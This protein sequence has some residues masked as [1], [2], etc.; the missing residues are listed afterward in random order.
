ML[1]T[2]SQA[3]SEEDEFVDIESEDVDSLL[4]IFDEITAELLKEGEILIC[5][6]VT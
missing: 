6:K 3:N 4:S 5:M 2:Y 1:S